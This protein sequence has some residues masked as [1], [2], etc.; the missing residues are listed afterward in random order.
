[1]QYISSVEDAKR[2]RRID[3]KMTDKIT[4]EYRINKEFVE[5]RT[6]VILTDDEY[7]KICEMLPDLLRDHCDFYAAL[8]IA[9][10]ECHDK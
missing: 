1:M 4:L 8:H 3:E 7:K 2:K 10:R 5:A 9:V 6:G